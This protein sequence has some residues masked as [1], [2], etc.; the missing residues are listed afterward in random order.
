MCEMWVGIIVD[1]RNTEK[2]PSNFEIVVVHVGGLAPLGNPPHIS[3]FAFVYD[4]PACL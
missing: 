2:R 4:S 3:I 1:Q